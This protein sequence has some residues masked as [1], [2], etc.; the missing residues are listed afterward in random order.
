MKLLSKTDWTLVDVP[1]EN[2]RFKKIIYKGEEIG[3]FCYQSLRSLGVGVLDDLDMDESEIMY[4]LFKELQMKDGYYIHEISIA[5]AFQGK[6]I[7][8]EIIEQFIDGG[9]TPV[10]LYSLADAEGFWERLGFK[11]RESYYYTWE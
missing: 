6:G 1:M 10:L 4:P 2:V 5:E 9:H 11:R 3:G 8:Q 7:G